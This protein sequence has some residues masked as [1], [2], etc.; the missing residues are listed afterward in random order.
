MGIVEQLEE[1]KAE[2][3][4][5]FEL[6]EP[7]L[8]KTYGPGKWSVRHLLHHLS[9]SEIVFVYRIKRVIAQPNQVI[10]VYDQDAWAKAL[11]YSTAPM[12]LARA[13]YVAAR[14]AIIHCAR[15]HYESADRVRFVHSETGV[16]TLRDEFDKVVS[17]NRQ[18]VRDIE[19]AL[20]GS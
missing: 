19:R 9:D 16:R 13:Q 7:Q 8:Q 3:L 2:T 11:D 4:E 12:E 18:H 6:A 15:R 5:Y 14:D 1:A 17:H 10:W 20:A